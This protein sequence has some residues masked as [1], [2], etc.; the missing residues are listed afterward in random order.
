M[1][2]PTVGRIVWFRS[3]SG[4]P[5]DGDEPLAGIITGVIDDNHVNLCVFDFSGTPHPKHN[6]FLYQ[7]EPE[8]PPC[9]EFA[10]WMPYQKGQAAKAEELEKQLGEQIPAAEE[11][12]SAA[13][14]SE[15]G[16]ADAA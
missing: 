16:P 10:V 8:G 5:V 2:K 4:L 13:T 6:V 7:D 14:P 15:E 9:E 1:I 12:P 3:V 11:P